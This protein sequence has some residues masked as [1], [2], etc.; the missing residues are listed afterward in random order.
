MKFHE[1]S[2]KDAFIIDLEAR[3][4]DRGMFARTM[5]VEEFANHG[6]ET[7]FVQQNQSVS[8]YRGTLRGMHLQ[9]VPFAEAKL[10]SCSRGVIVDIIVDMRRNSPTF[11]CHEAFE[12]SSEN[13]RQL[14]VPQGFAH[15]FQ[16]MVDDVEVRYLVSAPYTPE[17]EK[18][19]RYDDP[20]LAIRWPLEIAYISEKD[21]NWPYLSNTDDDE[22]IF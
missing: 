10:V 9:S 5:C 19:L 11:L 15:S 13:R 1:T 3:E 8:A 21:A 7:R 20:R 17:A 22:R 12:L 4:D 2:L 14:Y 16:S 6:L 18:G